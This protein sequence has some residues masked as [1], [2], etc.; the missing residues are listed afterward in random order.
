M[1]DSRI[2]DTEKMTA[3]WR[4]IRERTIAKLSFL[5]S[6]AIKCLTETTASQDWRS[7]PD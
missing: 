6:T 3:T 2:G 4:K 5:A 7:I 1:N